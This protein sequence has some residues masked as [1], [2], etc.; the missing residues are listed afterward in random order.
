MED[1]IYTLSFYKQVAGKNCEAVAEFFYAGDAYMPVDLLTTLPGRM[2]ETLED[3]GMFSMLSEEGDISSNRFFS[4]TGRVVAITCDD[5][6]VYTGVARAGTDYAPP[7][8]KFCV[9]HIAFILGKNQDPESLI[10]TMDEKME[11][12]LCGHEMP[13]IDGE[14]HPNR[15]LRKRL[16]K[17]LKKDIEEAD[18]NL[19]NEIPTHSKKD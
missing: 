1:G 8:T 10:R 19:K 2:T 3:E 13:F 12:K 18:L 9:I 7:K 6:V 16:R 14:L 11:F 15:R 5:G 17:R 4:K